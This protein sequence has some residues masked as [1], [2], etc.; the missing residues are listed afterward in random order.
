MTNQLTKLTEDLRTFALNTHI[1]DQVISIPNDC[2][3]IKPG[4]YKISDLLSFLA[5]MIEQ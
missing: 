4:D 5:D 2:Q 1:Q 3:F